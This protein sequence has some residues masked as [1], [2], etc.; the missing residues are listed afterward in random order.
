[1]TNGIITSYQ[2]Q[3]GRYNHTSGEIFRDIVNL[4]VSTNDVVFEDEDNTTIVE[5]IEYLQE[6]IEYGFQVRAIT[7]APGPY[8]DFAVNTTFQ[9]R[10]FLI[11]HCKIKC[12]ICGWYNIVHALASLPDTHLGKEVVCN[13]TKVAT[14]LQPA[15][16]MHYTSTPGLY[17]YF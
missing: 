11:I 8:T 1:M 9:A 12:Y 15:N 14:P 6:F 4:T 17:S 2:I 7:V 3:Y 13:L 5:V 10:M 16:N